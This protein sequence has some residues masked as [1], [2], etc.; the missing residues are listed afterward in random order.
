[1]G[2]GTPFRCW[3]W[4]ER[5]VWIQAP[6]SQALVPLSSSPPSALPPNGFDGVEQRGAPGRIQGGREAQDQRGQNHRHEVPELG[7]DREAFDEIDVARE[8]DE[9]IAPEDRDQSPAE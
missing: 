7:A 6:R 3:L 2:L 5:L 9:G 8:L 4:S 1:M